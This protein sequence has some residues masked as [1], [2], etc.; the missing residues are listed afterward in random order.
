MKVSGVAA[1]LLGPAGLLGAPL[2][3]RPR[4]LGLGHRL[5]QSAVGSARALLLLL[6]LLLLLRGGTLG[7][8]CAGR[9][10]F[11]LGRGAA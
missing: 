9:T 1:V 11:P 3:S 6:L 2:G 7:S 8:Q 10:L 4:A 5:A